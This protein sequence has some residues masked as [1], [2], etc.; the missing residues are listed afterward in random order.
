MAP[1]VANL[2]T[3]AQKNIF[4]K[5]HDCK[6][7]RQMFG[8]PQQELFAFWQDRTLRFVAAGGMSSDSSDDFCRKRQ[9]LQRSYAA[10]QCRFLG[11]QGTY[12]C[13]Q[14][15]SCQARKP[16]KFTRCIPPCLAHKCYRR[17]TQEDI[18][19][20]L[21]LCVDAET[22]NRRTPFTSWLSRSCSFVFSAVPELTAVACASGCM[23]TCQMEEE[24]R[25][26]R[27]LQ[28]GWWHSVTLES[29]D[30]R[31]EYNFSV[32]SVKIRNSIHTRV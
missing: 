31:H 23:G 29:S 5:A 11:R 9:A 28:E 19:H 8:R 13:I 25:E 10:Y 32:C 16:S 2:C 6:W 14:C 3:R 12:H 7:Q 20:M 1:W 17:R 30:L 26:W 15:F 4:F 21:S 18:H 22:F 24:S 27:P